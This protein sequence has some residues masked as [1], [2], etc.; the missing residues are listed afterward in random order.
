MDTIET[1]N[2]FP[3]FSKE[4]GAAFPGIAESSAGEEIKVPPEAAFA[5][6]E[7]KPEEEEIEL[8]G[9]ALAKGLP[10]W[11]IEP[12]HALVRRKKA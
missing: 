6:V 11:D 2:A 10:D 1:E 5:E 8:L 4:S 7:E 9:A 3:A 12:P